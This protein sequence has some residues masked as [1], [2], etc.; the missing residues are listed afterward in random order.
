MRL[1]S[2]TANLHSL[3]GRVTGKPLRLLLNFDDGQS[4]RL[5]VAGDGER[6][7]ADGQSLDGPFDMGECGAVEIGDVTQALGA[8]LRG[9]DV[10]DVRTLAMAENRVGVQLVLVAG[11]AF[12]IWVDGD[13]LYW[14]EEAAL[15]SHDWLDGVAPMPAEPVGV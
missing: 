6:M 8:H 12:Y 9:A 11:D 2:I 10:L 3:E 7:I 1:T 4:L 5:A 13:E 15:I 14:G